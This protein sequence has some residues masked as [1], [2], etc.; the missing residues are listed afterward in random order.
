MVFQQLDERLAHAS[1]EDRAD[2]GERRPRVARVVDGS[3]CGAGA[4]DH[5][6]VQRREPSHY[7]RAL[8]DQRV[9]DRD[10]AARVEELER[11]GE[12]S[13]R[14]TMAAAGVAEENQDLRRGSCRDRL[15]WRW[16]F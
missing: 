16:R 13:G 10:D 7:R 4:A 3:P 1:A 5:R 12:G 15:E 2:G 8:T 11:V 9:G 14:G 6:R